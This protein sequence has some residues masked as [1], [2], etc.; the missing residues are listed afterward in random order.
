MNVNVTNRLA[1]TICQDGFN[2]KTLG[3][4]KVL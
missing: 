3:K 1:C 2:Q 4:C